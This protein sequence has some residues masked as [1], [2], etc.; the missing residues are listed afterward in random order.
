MRD[1]TNAVDVERDVKIPMPDGGVLL[2]NVWHPVVSSRPR[3]SSNGRRTG[4]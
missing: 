3:P 1:A 2:A 4:G